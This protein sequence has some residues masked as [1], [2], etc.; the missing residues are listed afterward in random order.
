M[1][2][3]TKDLLWVA[4]LCGELDWKHCTPELLGDNMGAIALTA[5]PGKHSKSKHIENKYHM[6][7]RN[8]KLNRPTTRHIGTENMVAT[9]VIKAL[10]AVKFAHFREA[11]KVL[12][13]ARDTSVENAEINEEEA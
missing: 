2:E 11:M 12:P 10:G 8:V 7:R 9:I 1:A 6:T 13:L 5:K 3:A 4:D